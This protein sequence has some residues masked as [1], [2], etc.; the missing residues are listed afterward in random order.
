MFGR[1]IGKLEGRVETL[2]RD[3]DAARNDHRDIERRLSA[4]ESGVSEHREHHAA[5]AGSERESTR[6]RERLERGLLI[7]GGIVVGWLLNVVGR[8]AGWL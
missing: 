4:L 7:V 5:V 3:S 8:L 2:L 1:A 6:S